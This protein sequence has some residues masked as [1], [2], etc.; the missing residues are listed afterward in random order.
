MRGEGAAL[1]LGGVRLRDTACGELLGRFPE[2]EG[3]FSTHGYWPADLLLVF[4]SRANRDVL[5]STAANPLD[6]RDFT[7]RF[8]VWKRQLQATRRSLRFWVHLEVVGVP[9]VAWNLD[10][11]KPILGSSSW[12]ERLG[13]EMA[14]R[15]DMGSF[16]ITAWTDDVASLPKSKRLWLAEP[17]LFADD[18]DDLLL[19]VEALIP[20]E[21][22]LLDYEATVHVVKVED[23]A[24]HPPPGG[25]PGHSSGGGRSEDDDSG[26]DRGNGRPASGRHQQPLARPSAAL[27]AGNRAPLRRWRGGAERR[28]ALGATT[29]VQPWPSQAAQADGRVEPA[30]AQAG[31]ARTVGAPPLLEQQQVGIAEAAAV[32]LGSRP[33]SPKPQSGLKSLSVDNVE[34]ERDGGTNFFGFHLNLSPS[35]PSS[36]G[37]CASSARTGGWPKANPVLW[38]VEDGPL[39]PT[40]PLLPT[41][42]VGSLDSWRSTK[43]HNPPTP[44]SM[45]TVEL[46]QGAS[47]LR[48]QADEVEEGEIVEIGAATPP[49]TSRPAQEAAS[50][51]VCPPPTAASMDVE[52][53]LSFRDRCRAKRAALL[54]RPAPRK[55]RKKRTPP[56]VVRRS[57]RCA[58]RFAQGTPI[59]QQQKW[60]MVQLEIAREGEV[61]GDEALVA[62]LKY[63]EEKSM[64]SEHLT[65]CL[66]LFGWQAS[67]LPLV[68]GG[69]VDAV[70]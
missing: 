40:G 57:A 35:S 23:S 62:Y 1:E 2:L 45:F 17:L 64:T 43:D 69:D 59:K 48:T 5:L 7:L 29:V 4:D 60:L 55:P 20:D 70:V 16:R 67:A 36:A 38:L 22:A 14:N 58:G 13:S 54:P 52:C 39:S 61:I 44:M 56:S 10:T 63:F 41:G 12:L 50:P 27:D 24:T 31:L 46:S 11:A 42:S 34:L 53:M 6:G 21:V 30:P 66:A 37:D 47:P 68:D 28:V 51:V 18:D 49:A 33:A 3:H 8:G 26:D 25:A 32:Q 15:T 65:A 19:P 9:P